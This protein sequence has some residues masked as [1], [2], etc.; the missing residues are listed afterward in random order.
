ME[1]KCHNPSVSTNNSFI[2]RSNRGEKVPSPS[3][4]GSNTCATFATRCFLLVSLKSGCHEHRRRTQ[5]WIKLK[6][7]HFH[8]LFLDANRQRT[9]PVKGC[10]ETNTLR[11]EKKADSTDQLKLLSHGTWTRCL[12]SILHTCTWTE[13]KSECGDGLISQ[14][15]KVLLLFV[16]EPPRQPENNGLPRKPAHRQTH[17]LRGTSVHFLMNSER[18][19]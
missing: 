1:S 7:F 9:V 17:Y 3:T 5:Q 13:D 6:W 15:M 19:I 8:Q 11:W 18:G 10:N 4:V 16:E 2:R 14:I 12:Q